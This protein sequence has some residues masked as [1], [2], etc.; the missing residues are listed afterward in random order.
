L[1]P[2]VEDAARIVLGY[3]GS[4][5]PNENELDVI[6]TAQRARALVHV[7]YFIRRHIDGDRGAFDQIRLGADLLLRAEQRWPTLQAAILSGATG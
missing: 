1:I 6:A 2:E 7:A 4:Q 3:G 5:S